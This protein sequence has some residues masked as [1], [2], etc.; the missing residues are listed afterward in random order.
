MKNIFVILVTYEKPIEEVEG[1][2]EAHREFLA[3]GY[4]NGIL[5]M[6]GGQNPRIGGV[7]VG[8]FNS[9][10]EANE[11]ISKDPFFIH[12]VAKYELTEFVPS[13]YAEGIKD[14]I[15]GQ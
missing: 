4:K 12:S 9:K 6:S 7:I 1:H 14:Y 13:K 2:L 5:M 15:T 10:E 8:R 3:E 11:F